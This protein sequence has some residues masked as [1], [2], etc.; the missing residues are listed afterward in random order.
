MCYIYKQF[1]YFTRHLIRLG[2]CTNLSKSVLTPTQIPVFL[3]FFVDSVNKCFRLTNEK[4]QKFASLRE[5]CLDKEYLSV[6][7]LQQ[8]AGK[9]IS[10]ML[11]V[12]GAKLYTREMNRAISLG[13]KSNQKT[14]LSA[15]LRDEIQ[16]WRFLDNWEGQMVWKKERHLYLEI[17]SDASTFKRGGVIFFTS[18]KQEIYDFWREKDKQ[19]PIMVLEAKALLN[20]LLSI[21]D[22]IQGQRLD[23][24]VDNMALLNAWKNEGCKS[25]ELNV[26][27]KEIFKLVF[28]GDIVMNLIFVKSSDN[29]ADDASRVLKKSDASLSMGA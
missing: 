24:G 26:V 23:A 21:K 12:P 11:A 27:L 18:G 13:C 3:G 10:F 15:D 22:Q 16:S 8:L 1:I 2:Y 14:F 20:V 29:A 4:K 25:R 28:E 17:V 19:L 5:Q 7:E 6:L 9:C